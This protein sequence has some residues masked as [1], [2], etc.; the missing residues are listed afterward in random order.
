L[1]HSCL[2]RGYLFRLSDDQHGAW[3][4]LEQPQPGNPVGFGPVQLRHPTTEMGAVLWL[5]RA[6]MTRD[7]RRDHLPIYLLAF[8]THRA[9]GHGRCDD[10]GLL[11]ISGYAPCSARTTRQPNR[12][13]SRMTKP[14]HLLTKGGLP[15]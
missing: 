9:V 3:V 1:P 10:I 6:A 7:E 15:R 2:Q 14:L 5:W 11:Q 12:H 13:H 8:I 4:D